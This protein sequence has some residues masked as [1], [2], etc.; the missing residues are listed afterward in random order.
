MLSRQLVPTA[1]PTW[2]S[3]P[4]HSTVGW[5]IRWQ[6]WAHRRLV[7]SCATTQTSPW[8]S[9]LPGVISKV[10]NHVGTM[11]FSPLPTFAAFVLLG[12]LR[13]TIRHRTN[14]AFSSVY[15]SRSPI[16]QD[17]VI[18]SPLILFL[19]RYNFD[20]Q[21]KS[22]NPSTASFS[23]SIFLLSPYFFLLTTYHDGR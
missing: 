22:F 5:I 4:L 14:R 20:S 12:L 3:T 17:Q 9:W 2:S 23:S 10:W 21:N 1:I 13:L 11:L 15:I 18:S 6:R 8:V 19:S 7:A 16:H